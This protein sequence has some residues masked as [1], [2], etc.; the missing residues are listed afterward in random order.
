MV[1]YSWNI[2]GKKS[3]AD[4]GEDIPD[5]DMLCLQ[6]AG[7][8]FHGAPHTIVIG[9]CSYRSCVVILYKRHSERLHSWSSEG[10]FPR[11]R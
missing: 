7:P 9:E 2:E 8:F 11:L 6:E 5:W 10:S 4:L 3:L 1:V